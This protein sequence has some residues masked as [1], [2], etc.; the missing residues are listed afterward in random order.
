MDYVK[1]GKT[2][3]GVSR[4]C[5]GCMTYG[6]SDRGTHPWTLD[7]EK[8]ILLATTKGEIPELKKV[9]SGKAIVNLQ[10]LVTSVPVS[11]YTVD[12]VTRLVRAT[13]SG[14]ESRV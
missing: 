5:L 11:E 9:L 4:L 1:F 2:G 3:L 14:A 13:R 8:K 6:I 10:K 12:Y 7:E